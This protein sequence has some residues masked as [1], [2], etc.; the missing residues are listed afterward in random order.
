M[1]FRITRHASASPPA[2]ALD[3]LTS[4]IGTRR[5]GVHFAR[6]GAEIRADLRRDDPVAMTNDERIDIGRRAVL[7][8]IGQ[9]CER[10]PELE[11]DWFAVSPAD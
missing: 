7:E 8:I 10:T 1:K 6:V 2:N 5:D 9:V 3:L 11:T 4:S